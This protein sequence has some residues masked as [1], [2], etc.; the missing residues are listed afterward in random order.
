VVAPR[1]RP[2]ARPGGTG[3]EAYLRLRDL[4]VEGVFLPGQRLTHAKLMDFLRVGRTP[5]RTA[6]SRLQADGLVVAKPNQGVRVAPAPVGSAEEIYA[7]RFLVEPPLLEALAGGITEQDVA[8]LR[9][10]LTRMEQCVDEPAAFQRAH[11]EFHTAE[12]ASFA[13]PFIDGLV[14][15]MYRHLHRHQRIH[16]VRQRYPS[17]FLLLDRE[18]VEALE[19]RDGLRA[20]RALELHLLDAALSFLVDVD[21]QH[22]PELLVAVAAAN[23][24]TIER[25]ADG[26]VPMPARITWHTRC[27][28]L[29]P[30]A[31]AHLVYDRRS[32]STS[33]S[34]TRARGRRDFRST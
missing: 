11:R 5:L 13:S 26:G 16:V 32:P 6:L 1:T 29:P 23:G 31:T 9:A 17:D 22:R 21:S 8:Q 28:T 25:A 2:L 18:T 24:V 27:D 33:V 19:A 7:L 14:H 12:R 15:D 4:I 34:R 3:D 30:L 20:R 10:L